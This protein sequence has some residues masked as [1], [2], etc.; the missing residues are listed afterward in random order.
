M[1]SARQFLA[2]QVLSRHPVTYYFHQMR[3]SNKAASSKAA[4]RQRRYRTSRRLVSIDI[5]PATSDVLVGLRK[6]TGLTTDALLAVALE[7]Y[8]AGLTSGALQ[9]PQGMTA[10]GPMTQDEGSSRRPTRA[11]RSK[12]LAS[13]G[14]DETPR[15]S[16]S[17]KAAGPAL[18]RAGTNG[19]SSARK[20]SSQA[21]APA[22]DAPTPTRQGSLDLFS[23]R[24]T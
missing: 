17:S 7:A 21:V 12:R 8:A 20:N 2:A 24:E 14:D 19:A 1:S 11:K 18:P 5:G 6:R 9:T 10:L 15:H 4:D 13:P 16:P 23:D 22:T 3:T